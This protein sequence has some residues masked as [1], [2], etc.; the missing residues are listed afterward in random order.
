MAS[1]IK[2][3]VHPTPV[4]WIL[5]MLCIAGVPF[6]I[7]VFLELGRAGGV[8]LELVVMAL[9]LRAMMMLADGAAN[10]L[11]SLP[12]VLLFAETV[13]DGLTV[14][15]G[16]WA[17]VWQ[18]LVGPLVMGLIHKMGSAGNV[19]LFSPAQFAMILWICA[20]IIHTV[21]MAIYISPDQGRKRL[22]E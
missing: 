2:V 6:G 12:R 17:W 5:F 21:R 22:Y 13:V 4:E 1:Q 8:M 20:M 11:Q 10:R 18:P 16:F 3:H 7:L 14:A 19:G 9:C 15:V